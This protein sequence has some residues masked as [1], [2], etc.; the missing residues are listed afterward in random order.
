MDIA[1]VSMSMAETKTLQGFQIGMIK[2]AME[3]V[4]QTGAQIAQMMS[5]MDVPEGSTIDIRV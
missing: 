1:S 2:K 4:E 5:S 3:Q